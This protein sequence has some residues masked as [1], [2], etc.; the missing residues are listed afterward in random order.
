MAAKANIKEKKYIP[1][2]NI[3]ELRLAR[4]WSQEA[5]GAKIGMRGPNVDR[6]EGGLRRLDTGLLLKLCAVFDVSV[7]KITD[8]PLPKVNAVTTDPVML[9]LVVGWLIEA[10]D[11]FK[12]EYDSKQIGKWTSYLY[13]DICD[14]D[15]DFSESRDLTFEFAKINKSKKK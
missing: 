10:C 2:N 6:L 15:L 3:E 13:T 1:P 11:K 7:D 12:I 14:R 9:G 5:L 4:G 8:L